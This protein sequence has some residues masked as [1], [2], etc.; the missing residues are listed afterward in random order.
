[1]DMGWLLHS[2]AYLNDP[3][4][5]FGGVKSSVSPASRE[6]DRLLSELK[7]FNGIK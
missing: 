2:W 3:V 4:S 7:V 5:R 6:A 1:M